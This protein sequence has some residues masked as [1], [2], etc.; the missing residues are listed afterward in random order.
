VGKNLNKTAN[1]VL[2]DWQV[3][4]MNT[5]H[6]GYSLTAIDWNVWPKTWGNFNDATPRAS[7]SGPVHYGRKFDSATGGM[8]FWD[9]T[10]FTSTPAGDYGS[11]GNGTIRG[12]GLTSFDMSLQK[13]FTI[14]KRANMQFRAEAINVFNHPIFQMPD[15]FFS[16][17]NAFGVAGIING[18]A[19]ATEGERQVQFGLKLFY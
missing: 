11:C 4:V 14:N 1:T 13:V 6:A 8:R 17:N 3:T 19:S 7:C 16:D 9:S 10:N 5:D 2:S 15:T 12:P 18:A